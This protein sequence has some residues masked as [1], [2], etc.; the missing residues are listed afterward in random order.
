M[1]IKPIF[2]HIYRIACIMQLYKFFAF[3]DY[4]THKANISRCE[5]S[6]A[7]SQNTPASYALTYKS[8]LATLAKSMCPSRPHRYVLGRQMINKILHGARK[9]TD[10][11]PTFTPLSCPAPHHVVD[12][13]YQLGHLCAFSRLSIYRSANTK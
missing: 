4:D 7:S 13:L 5:V 8:P 10:T 2:A 3:L 9:G 11:P 6:T 12:Y 1:F